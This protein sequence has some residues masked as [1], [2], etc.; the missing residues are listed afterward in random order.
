MD[1]E[2]QWP[3]ST[4]PSPSMSPVTSLLLLPPM[5]L[6]TKRRLDVAVKW[7]FFRNLLHGGDDDA[8]RVYRWHIQKRS[9]ERMRAGV[10]TDKWKRS[11]DNYVNAACDLYGLMVL[12]GFLP[13]GRIPVDPNGELLDGSH[14][15][16][17]A[18][19]LAIEKVPVARL[20]MFAWAPHWDLPWFA[21]HK[22][23]RGDLER[24]L[25]D[26]DVMRQ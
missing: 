2:C 22:M 23:P 6:L 26:W 11:L 12:R 21:M 7:R 16:A 3:R 24:L 8:E 13:D 15:L 19:A 9:G 4:P 18:I 20:P 14:R 10:P 5:S 1:G 17:C 25:A